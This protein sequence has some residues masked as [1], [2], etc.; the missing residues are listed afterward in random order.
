MPYISSLSIDWHGVL[1][2]CQKLISRYK[3]LLSPLNIVMIKLYQ[4][5][6]EAEL[7]LQRWNGALETAEHLLQPYQ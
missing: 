5:K 1:D 3:A 4:E 6:L 7:E 2:L